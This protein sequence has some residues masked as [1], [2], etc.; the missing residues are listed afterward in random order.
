MKSYKIDF[1]RPSGRPGL[2]GLALLLAGGV[3]LASMLADSNVLTATRDE[4]AGRLAQLDDE[5]RRAR[6]PKPIAQQRLKLD[7]GE[8]SQAKILASLN[9]RWQTAF[10]ALDGAQGKQIALLSIEAAQAKRQLRIVAEARKLTD[11][12]DYVAR[13]N[14]QAGVRRAVLQQ[15]EILEDAEFKPVRFTVV[16][17]LRA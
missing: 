17:E 4:Q 7:V 13:L 12:L 11:A 3:L 14:E 8:A 16:T 1:A 6:A 10:S 5:L 9:F 15:H 2:I